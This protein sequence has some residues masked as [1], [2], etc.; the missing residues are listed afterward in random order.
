M[1]F[2]NNL[3]RHYAR[4]HKSHASCA[5]SSHSWDGYSTIRNIHGH[6]V[7]ISSH[8]HFI[9]RYDIEVESIIEG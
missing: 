8:F 6:Q 2:T 7:G 1:E 4:F 9:G 5:H 3:M